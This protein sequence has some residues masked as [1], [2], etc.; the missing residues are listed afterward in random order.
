M[1]AIEVRDRSDEL[2]GVADSATQGTIGS[3]EMGYRPILRA[4]E[5]LET[6]P[7]MIITQHS[8]GGKAPQYFTR[9]FNLDHGTDF[10]IDL[11]GMG[12]NLAS[13]VHGE[14]YADMN[15]VIPELIDHMDYEKGPYFAANG[16][17]SNAG[18]AHIHFISSAPENYFKF[19]AG[20]D[21]FIRSVLV[22]DLPVKTGDLVTGIEVSHENGPWTQPDNFIKY[23][24]FVRYSKGTPDLG[25]SVTGMIYHGHWKAT[26]Q[27]SASAVDDGLISFYG[28]QDKD[29][30]GTSER[31]SLQ[32]EWHRKDADSATS[33][34]FYYFHYTLNLYSNFTYYLESPNGDE[35]EQIGRD[36][37]AGL[38]IRHTLYGTFLGKRMET[39]LGL[40]AQNYWISNGLYQS[41]DDVMTAKV[42]YDGNVIPEVT[43]LSSIL[44]TQ[45]GIYVENHI[46]W[47]DWFRTELGIRG[48]IARDQV[49]DIVPGNSGIR[50]GELPSPKVGLVF[51]PWDKTEFYVQGGYSFHSNDARS[52]T[53]TVNPDGTPV[54]GLLPVL[55]PAYGGEVGVR[56][57]IIPGLQSTISLWA[58][59]N[60]SELYFNGLD[61]D[62]GDISNSQQA[63]RRFGVEWSNYYTPVD[64]LTFDLDFADSSAHF[65]SP[66]TAD[67]DPTPGGTQVDEAIHV[68]VAGGATVNVG[69]GVSLTLRVRDFGP[70]PLVSDSSISSP[71]TTIVNLG[72]AY[73]LNARLRFTCDILNLLD[74][75][76]HDIDYYYDS[77][78]S[79]TSPVFSGDHF[80]PVEPIAVRAGFQVKL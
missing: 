4:G 33:I 38:R 41:I 13:H 3:T 11:D 21:G 24:G 69:S 77:K 47:S 36:D 45:A 72:F 26:D 50:V 55:I 68:S 20:T 42:D 71:S 40:Q 52:A 35:F 12:L 39:S 75:K 56:T 78:D 67:E 63:T 44:Q 59:H 66:T 62:T 51:G 74:R 31:L 73:Q 65:V 14:G 7:G 48:D 8:G 5:V 43:K 79:P 15:I 58:L 76:D 6:I 16:D 37:S 28:N 57:S 19:E 49:K 64:W 17:F 46:W 54:G 30:G 80:H 10:A 1:D 22:F 60:K 18:A 25:Y 2:V 29:D 9:G 61:Q 23:N 32:A 70:R 53:S 34:S 27:V